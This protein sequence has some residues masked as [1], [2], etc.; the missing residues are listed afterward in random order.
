MRYLIL[1]FTLF[2]TDLQAAD[3]QTAWKAL[4][5]ER[6]PAAI[7][8]AQ[9]LKAEGD[10]RGDFLLGYMHLFGKG[11][12]ADA[13]KA[14]ALFKKASTAGFN[15]ATYRLGKMYREGHPGVPQNLDAALELL[16]IAADNGGPNAQFQLAQMLEFGE[17]TAPNI[18][19]AVDYYRQAANQKHAYARWNLGYFHQVGLVVE[20]DTE[21]AAALY[22]LA[23]SDGA[24]KWLGIEIH[25][26]LDPLLNGPLNAQNCALAARLFNQLEQLSLDTDR[27]RYAECQQLLEP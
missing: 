15:G 25:R 1:G 3:F 6:Y 7:S 10:V 13:V 8:E 24:T 20:K 12:E 21:R 16:Q 26:R 14:E 27:D 19:R 9:A 22:K 18:E 2:V 23:L 17:G 11:L 4:F 5:S